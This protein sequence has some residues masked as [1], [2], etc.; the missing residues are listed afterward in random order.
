MCVWVGSDDFM[1]GLLPPPSPRYCHQPFITLSLALLPFHPRLDFPNKHPKSLRAPL[2][3]NLLVLLL[4]S[5]HLEDGGAHVHNTD[6]KRIKSGVNLSSA[7]GETDINLKLCSG[8]LMV[9]FYVYFRMKWV[10]FRLQRRCVCGGG[11]WGVNQR[12]DCALCGIILNEFHSYLWPD[13]A[14]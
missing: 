9:S 13:R 4:L 5:R 8:G 3:G 2:W 10:L 6:S 1:S 7:A 14:L 11:G 12:L